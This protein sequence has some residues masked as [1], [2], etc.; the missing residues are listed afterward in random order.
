MLKKI[1]TSFYKFTAALSAGVFVSTS[2]EANTFN[3]IAKNITETT[4]DWTGMVSVVGYVIGL[5]L[6]GL[7]AMNIKQHVD[8]PDSN[9]LRKGVIKLAI[10]G[11]LFAIP[12]VSESALEAIGN[13]GTPTKAAL[14][15]AAT[16]NVQ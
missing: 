5:G 14:V 7:G 3:T 6:M 13:G 12:F 16:L 1:N 15:N 2:A 10:G 9:P 4:G 8:S 11:A